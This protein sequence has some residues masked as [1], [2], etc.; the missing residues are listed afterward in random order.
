ML[1]VLAATRTGA[2]EAGVRSAEAHVHGTATLSLVRDG[3][4]LTV[5]L[6]TPVFNLTGFE[7][8][9]AS[10]AQSQAWARVLQALREPGDRLLQPSRAA[11]CSLVDV[12]IED[13]FHGEAAPGAEHAAGEDHSH[14]DLHASYRFV[15]DRPARL[16]AFEVTL[17]ETF[18]GIERLDAVYLSRQRQ[19]GGTLTASRPRFRLE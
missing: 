2:A 14:A 11:R 4:S 10:Q 15:C 16:R 3:D 9:P 13:P 12:D 6:E 19:T 1:S 7:H 8:A 17:F 18:P 5:R